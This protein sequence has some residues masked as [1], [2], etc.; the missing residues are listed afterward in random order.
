M[1]VGDLVKFKAW[2]RTK[3]DILYLVTKTWNDGDLVSLCAFPT[4]Q[5]FQSDKLEIV[6][7]SR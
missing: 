4:N 2:C 1:K 5:V 7:E 6:S 3:G